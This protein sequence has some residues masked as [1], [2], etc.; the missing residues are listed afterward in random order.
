MIT[1]KPRWQVLKLD[2]SQL[3]VGTLKWNECILKEAV[4]SALKSGFLLA[5]ILF[6]CN[7]QVR[8]KHCLRVKESYSQVKKKTIQASRKKICKEKNCKSKVTFWVQWG[9]KCEQSRFACKQKDFECED[10][11]LREQSKIWAWKQG[12]ILSNLKHML[13]I[14]DRDIPLQWEASQ[15]QEVFWY[16]PM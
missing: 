10:R 7:M 4:M 6:H 9:F 15:L 5:K 11:V 14:K 12:N 2:H 16:V 8:T 13:L 3:L 1:K